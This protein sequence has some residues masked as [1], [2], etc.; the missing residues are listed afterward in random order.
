[1]GAVLEHRPYAVPDQ[2]ALRAWRSLTRGLVI[3]G[4][5]PAPPSSGVLAEVED[6][7]EIPPPHMWDHAHCEFCWA[8][9]LAAASLAEQVE[10]DVSPL[11]EGYVTVGSHGEHWIC[12]KCF[13][14]F[15]DEFRWSVRENPDAQQRSDQTDRV[16]VG[17]GGW[18]VFRDPD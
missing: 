3:E 7:E 2:G 9:F 16:D 1:M 14:D 8:T 11:T 17:S 6:W 12:D 18:R 15:K 10:L 13:A 4:F 5:H